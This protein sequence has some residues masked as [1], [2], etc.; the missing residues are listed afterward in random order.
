MCVIVFYKTVF[1]DTIMVKTDIF[2]I[3]AT[4]HRRIVQT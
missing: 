3:S 1:F 2:C 4:F